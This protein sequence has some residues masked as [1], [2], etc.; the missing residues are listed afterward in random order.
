MTERLVKLKENY[1]K[2]VPSITTHRARA[3]TK[4][5]KENLLVYLNQ[6]YVVNVL[7]HCCETAPLVIQ[8]HE[9]IV[10]APNGKPRAG[11][12]SPDIA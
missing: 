5:A 11:A 9:L 1:L 10:G 6:F 3:I 8:D 2:Q 7:K 12:F 4:I